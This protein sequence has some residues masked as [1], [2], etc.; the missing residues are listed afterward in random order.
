MK[1]F[2]TIETFDDSIYDSETFPDK[3]RSNAA[4]RKKTYFKSKR[5]F[6]KIYLKGFTP[7]HNAEQI[8]RGMLRKTNVIRVFHE[9]DRTRFGTKFS[10]IRRQEAS[11]NKLAYYTMGEYEYE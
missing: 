1:N 5:R 9:K 6:D 2:E 7:Y 4:R 11:N 3:D 10:T 8:I